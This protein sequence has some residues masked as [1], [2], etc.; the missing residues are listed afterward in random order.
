MV[1]E[2]KKDRFGLDRRQKCFIMRV[3]RYW[4]KLFREVADVLSLEFLKARLDGALNNG[5]V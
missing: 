4:N 3:S 5:L 2:L 1:F